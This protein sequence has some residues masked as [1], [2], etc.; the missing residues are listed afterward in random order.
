MGR[1]DLL[2]LPVFVKR[3]AR[4]RHTLYAHTEDG[5]DSALVESKPH[6][7]IMVKRTAAGGAFFV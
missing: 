2:H 3:A 7:Y 5:E 4:A 1:K 6:P